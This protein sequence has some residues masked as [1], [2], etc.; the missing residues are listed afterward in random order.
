MESNNT[1]TNSGTPHYRETF[2]VGGEW[3]ETANGKHVL[4]GQMYV[5][6]LIPAT[7]NKSPKHDPIVFIHGFTRS[8]ADWLTKPDGKPGWAFYF[9]A[10]GFEVYLVDIPFRGRSPWHPDDGTLTSVPVEAL[11]SLLL[12][13]KYGDWPQAKL[14]TQWPGTGEFGD[15]NCDQFF[16]SGLPVVTDTV[17]QEKA[18]AAA[19]A[20]LLDRIGKPTIVVGHSAG[21]SAP[22]LIADKRPKLISML[23]GLEPSGPPFDKKAVMPGPGTVYGVAFSPITYDPPVDNPLVDLIRQ[24]IKAPSEELFDG[25][26]QASSPPPRQLT[27]LKGIRT[28]VVTAEA[29]YHAQYDWIIVEYLN[30]AGV[31]AEHMKLEDRGITGNGHMMFVE[32][33]SDQVAAEIIKWIDQANTPQ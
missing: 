33:N 27:N 30:Q 12:H 7:V 1:T 16:R 20:A 32:E 19:G 26:I 23:I 9:L 21:G 3:V 25:T 28:L 22:W 14:H 6:R 15:P 29:S 31:P 2:Y 10:R 8:G 11:Q 18:T 24:K 4:R 13:K 17:A 5:E